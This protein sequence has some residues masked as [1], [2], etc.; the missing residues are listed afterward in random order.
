MR[1]HEAVAWG[2]QLANGG[3]TVNPNLAPDLD[4]A[5]IWPLSALQM[6]AVVVATAQK[7]NDG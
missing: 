1:A 7:G 3:R 6:V 4:A 2:T 5:T